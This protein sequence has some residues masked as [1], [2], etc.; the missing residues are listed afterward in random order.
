VSL[1]E[2]PNHVAGLPANT[3]QTPHTVKLKR[4]NITANGV[5]PLVNQGVT[6]RY[7]VLDLSDCYASSNTISGSDFS[8]SFPNDMNVIKDNQY[9]VGIIL[10]GKLTAIGY[11]AVYECS[12]LTSVVIPESV[13]S[14]GR[15]AFYGCNN[16]AGVTFVAGSSI[17]A[18]N[19]GT[20]P[21]TGY[22]SFPTFPG[23]LRDKYLAGNGGAGTYMRTVPA[24]YPGS[25]GTWTKQ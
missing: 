9:I 6:N 15:T 13:T 8:T 2:L 21:I 1:A 20:G 4:T 7:V 18:G 17:A 12:S 16:L 23:D 19:F 14:I 24:A 11:S 3:A 10:P 25:T 5:M 22:I